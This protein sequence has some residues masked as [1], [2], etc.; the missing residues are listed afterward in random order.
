[1][2]PGQQLAA[3]PLGLPPLNIQRKITRIVVPIEEALNKVRV[4]PQ[5]A[6]GRPGQA[7]RQGLSD[8]EVVGFRKFRLD[9]L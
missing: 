4:F 3:Y 9:S 2:L 1:M 8:K 7:L 5:P 6:A